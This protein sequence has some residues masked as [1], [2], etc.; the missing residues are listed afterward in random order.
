MKAEQLIN[1]L[2]ESFKP[3]ED[4]GLEIIVSTPFKECIAS[5]TYKLLPG[6]PV[7]L[8]AQDSTMALHSSYA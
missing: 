8:V 7:N 1:I 4:K 2:P 5:I 3:F 6:R